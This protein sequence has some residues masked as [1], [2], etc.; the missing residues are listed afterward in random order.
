MPLRLS[1][2][3]RSRDVKDRY[4]PPRMN[5]GSNEMADPA[6]RTRTIVL[7]GGGSGGHISPGLAIAEG[8][9]EV[10]SARGTD[11]QMLFLCSERAIDAKMLSEA[12]E[13]FIAL[14]A[15]PFSIHPV[16]LW[17]FYRQFRASRKAARA[18]LQ[19]EGAVCVA[20]LGGFAAAPVMMAARDLGLPRF[21][22]NLDDPPG[23][24]NKMMAKLGAEV[25]SA[26]DVHHDVRFRYRKVGFPIRRR[27]LAPGSAAEC[28]TRLGLDPARPVLLITGASQGS[29]SMNQLMIALANHHRDA[30]RGWQVLHLCGEGEIASRLKQAYADAGVKAMVQEFLFEMGLAWGAAELAVSR[31]GANSVAEAMANG[32]P[33]VFLPYPYH[34]DDHQKRNAEPMAALGGAVIVQ[35]RIEAEANMREAGRVVLEL[36]SD[37][38]RRAAMRRE[39]VA[40]RGKPASHE[41]A[42]I[43]LEL[44]SG[45]AA[46]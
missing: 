29:S 2:Q 9:R 46:V 8:L 23:K 5:Q 10:A 44:A 30:L 21:L 6:A 31:A 16:K 18:I 36:M 27:T 35:D 3:A 39:L 15:K 19:R 20:A 34:K 25:L 28:R 1:C 17:R 32:V 12:G 38:N 45:T 24:A 40:K 22:I 42:S 11:V 4:T 37:A 43:L 7:A 41:I 26:I 14:P 13:R 33:T